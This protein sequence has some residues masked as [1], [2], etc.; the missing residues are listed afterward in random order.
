M[1]STVDEITINY[2]E[3][4]KKII[5]EIEKE[6]ISKGGSWV[7]IGFLYKEF[8][9]R[10]EEYSTPKVSIRRYRKMDGSYKQQSKFNISGEKQARLVSKTLSKWF[11][12][13]S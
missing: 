5:D 11:P 1:A 9:R 4:G 7:T 8:N 2:E 10:T 6:V 13:E 12:E 3:D